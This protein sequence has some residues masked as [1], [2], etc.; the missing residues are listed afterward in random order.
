MDHG[1]ASGMVA[2]DVMKLGIPARAEAAGA[3]ALHKIASSRRSVRRFL[4]DP[5]EP[6]I[7]ERLFQTAGWAPSAHNRQPWRFAVLEEIG[8]KQRLARAMGDKLRTDR[9]ADGDAA[10]VI[11]RDVERSYFRISE[12][13]VVIVACVYMRDMDTYRDARRQ[14][15]EVLMAVQSTAMAVQNL[16]LAAHAEGLGA[17]I[18]CAP[19]FCGDAVSEALGLPSDWQPQSLIT[20]GWPA[21]PGRVRE[22]FDLDEIVWRPDPQR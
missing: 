17:S 10:E 15:A 21:G 22:R 11:E 6:A 13:P 4:N 16:L 9:A 19:L 7:L 3:D 12:A 2:I 14:A 20:L 18:M 8:W 5:I 1:L